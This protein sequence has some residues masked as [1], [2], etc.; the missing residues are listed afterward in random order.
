MDTGKRIRRLRIRKGM[1]QADLADKA[2]Y[3]SKSSIA[4]IEQSDR[5]IPPER[6][7]MIAEALDTSVDYLRYGDDA[8]NKELGDYQENRDYLS[9]SAPSLIPYLEDLS[10]PN[11][12]IL[13]DKIKDLEPEDV[14]S[15][16][17]VIELI[18]KGV[19]K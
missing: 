16:L 17:K 19:F 7:E 15:V 11:K 8:Y 18:N 1:T 6:L 4:K 12:R 5:Y 2:G 9:K 13:F 14:K 10:D 3:T